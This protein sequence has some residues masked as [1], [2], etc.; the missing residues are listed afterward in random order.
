MTYLLADKDYDAHAWRKALRQAGPGPVLSSRYNRKCAI[1]Y[2]NPDTQ[3]ATA[4]RTPSVASKT[5]DVW[6]HAMISAHGPSC[7][8]AS[9]LSPSPSSHVLRA[10]W[11]C[12]RLG[13]SSVHIAATKSAITQIPGHRLHANA[14]YS[15][16]SAPVSFGPAETAPPPGQT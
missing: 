11:L 9:S 6:Q 5:F 4:L 2:D 10:C 1:R 7:Q 3:T 8:P 15:Q 16:A 14:L 13:S 12:V